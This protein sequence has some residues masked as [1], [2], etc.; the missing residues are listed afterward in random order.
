[1]D[2]GPLVQPAVADQALDVTHP[3]RAPQSIA[4]L[5]ARRLRHLAGVEPVKERLLA[6]LQLVSHL[7]G[8]EVLHARRNRRR[9]WRSATQYAMS[10]D[11]GPMSQC[12]APGA[13][14]E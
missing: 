1:M 11:D 12:A 7:E 2:H 6:D 4:L 8:G 14:R 3:R 13:A 9:F 5:V 10:A